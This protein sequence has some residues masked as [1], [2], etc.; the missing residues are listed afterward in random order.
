[1]VENFP[2]L[3]EPD[4]KARDIAASKLG[5]SGKTLD[6]MEA[7]INKADELRD[8]GHEEEADEIIETLNTQSVAK[9]YEKVAPPK[10]KSAQPDTD[11]M[12]EHDDKNAVLLDRLQRKWNMN[13]RD[14]WRGASKEVKEK[15]LCFIGK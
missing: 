5:I 13:M 7:V 12:P 15:F 1:M 4:V 11:N 9:A 8:T 2:P 14:D 3:P 6:K 10:P